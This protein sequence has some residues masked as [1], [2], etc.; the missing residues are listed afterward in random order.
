MVV[1]DVTED[2][3]VYVGRST[4]PSRGKMGGNSRPESVWRSSLIQMLLSS[5]N[6]TPQMGAQ[7]EVK[8]YAGARLAR[9]MLI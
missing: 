4:Q 5:R 9:G 2:D 8:H 1:M 3:H 6:V 7:T